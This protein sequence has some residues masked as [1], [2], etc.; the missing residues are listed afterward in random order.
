MVRHT[1]LLARVSGEADVTRVAEGRE[2]E[3]IRMIDEEP[4]ISTYD[5]EMGEEGYPMIPGGEL[6]GGGGSGYGLG[7]GEWLVIMLL[8]GLIVVGLALLLQWRRDRGRRAGWRGVRTGRREPILL[9]FHAH[10]QRHEPGEHR[11]AADVSS[12]GARRH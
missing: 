1:A 11:D 9:Q 6:T 10:A 4:C 7:I 5:P 3:T 2:P 12:V 8:W